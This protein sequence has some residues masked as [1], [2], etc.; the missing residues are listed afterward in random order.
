ML[1]NK[2]IRR[3]FYDHKSVSLVEMLASERLKVARV[4]GLVA[5]NPAPAPDFIAE[6]FHPDYAGDTSINEHNDRKIWAM[7]LDGRLG[8]ALLRML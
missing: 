8:A 7:A 1:E 5:V 2:T 6:E 3:D 4:A